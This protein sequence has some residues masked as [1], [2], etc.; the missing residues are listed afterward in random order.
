MI[1]SRIRVRPKTKGTDRDADLGSCRHRATNTEVCLR[2]AVRKAERSCNALP[3][4]HQSRGE[5]RGDHRPDAVRVNAI[6][7]QPN[8]VSHSGDLK[9][10]VYSFRKRDSQEQRLYLHFAESLRDQFHQSSQRFIRVRALGTNHKLGSLNCR[11]REDRKD[12]LAIKTF[13]SFDDLDRRLKIV[14]SPSEQ[15]C[16]AQVDSQG[17][18]DGH[19]RGYFTVGHG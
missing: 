13:V 4:V 11:R 1:A 16:R 10:D 19:Y 2:F 3:C 7:S 6:D 18:Q 8:A 9:R 15:I 17:I 5:L 14:R 12:T